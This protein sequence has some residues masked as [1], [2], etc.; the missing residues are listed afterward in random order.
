VNGD[1]NIEFLHES[2]VRLK[3]RIG[4]EIPNSCGAISPSALM[5]PVRSSSRSHVVSGKSAVPEQTVDGYS[6]STEGVCH[7]DAGDSGANHRTSS[8][9]GH[10]PWA[11]S[12]PAHRPRFF[13]QFTTLQ[14]ISR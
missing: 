3:T 7:R 13:G 2:P 10:A 6:D 11:R 5:R 12:S 9:L 4:W 8:G 1:R 14:F